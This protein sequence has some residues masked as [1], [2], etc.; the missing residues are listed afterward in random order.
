V[1]RRGTL[2][3]TGAEL[4]LFLLLGLGLV[5]GGTVLR[6]TGRRAPAVAG[7]APAIARAVAGADPLALRRT[8]A[9]EAAKLGG[10]TQQRPP[11]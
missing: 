9:L 3:F 4:T 11:S 8:I 6:T 10:H 7:D 2:P 5:I 1:I